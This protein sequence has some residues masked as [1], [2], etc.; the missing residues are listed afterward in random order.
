[1]IG[2][3]A[4]LLIIGAGAALSGVTE[5]GSAGE[6]TRLDSFR[7]AAPSSLSFL[8]RWLGG[9]RDEGSDALELVSEEVREEYFSELPFG[10][11]VHEK[12]Q[13][14]EIDPSLVIAIVEV[15]SAFDTK[16]RSPRG[17]VGLM[18]LR[19]DTGRWMGAVNLLD[20]SQ[21]IEAGTKYLRYLEE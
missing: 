21:N 15:E 5:N 2:F 17:A 13:K 4:A 16:A 6:S 14:Y 12:A 20:P 18:Q 3:G 9:S 8:D 10:E 1:M 7:E 19:P 11:I